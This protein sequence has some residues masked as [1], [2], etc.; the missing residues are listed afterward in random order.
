MTTTLTLLFALGSPTAE[1]AGFQARTM[2]D[3]LSPLEVERGLVLG[4]GWLELGLGTDVKVVEGEW[5]SDGEKVDW[6]NTDEL[7]TTQRAAIRYG[8]TRR[9]EFRWIFTTN[10]ISL[11]NSEYGTDITQFGVG[12]QFFGYTYELYRG[13]APVT[14]L[15]IHADYKGPAGNE[16]P[17]SNAANAFNFSK[18][19]TTTGT[20]DIAFGI[21][22]KRQLGPAAIEVG[23]AYVRRMSGMTMYAVET[24]FYSFAGRLKPGDITKVDGSLMLQ[25][26]PAA[27]HG[28][29][30]AQMRQVTRIGNTTTGIDPGA[31]LVALEGSDGT[32]VDATAGAVLGITRGVDFVVGATIPVKGEDLMFWPI[33][34]LHPTRG[35][36]YS[37]SFEFRY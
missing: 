29:L 7:Y 36:T 21:R 2:R 30:L 24:E 26:G 10:Y 14:S 19:I 35:N 33:E 15:V 18:F 4:K 31:D 37:G 9:G 3:D 34:D 16:I 17:G 5:S 22:G 27:L 23:A 32:A 1:A 25:L 11:T 8:I 13:M 28:G 20:S 12:D 6:E